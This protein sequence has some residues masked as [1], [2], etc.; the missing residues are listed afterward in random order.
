MKLRLF[1]A[2]FV[3]ALVITTSVFLPQDA[4]AAPTDSGTITVTGTV[5]PKGTSISTA[6]DADV[7]NNPIH[8]EQEIVVTVSY[9]STNV[10]S[11]PLTFRVEWDKA[12]VEGATEPN[13]ELIEYVI[14][15]AT[16]AY[17]DTAPVV[18]LQNRRITWS[19]AS[20]P[21]QSQGEEVSFRLRTTQGYTGPLKATIPL[22]V[23]VLSPVG[24]ADHETSIEYQ[25]LPVS[26]S[27]TPSPSSS[28]T[29]VTT[30]SS[31][32]GSA[33]VTSVQREFFFLKSLRVKSL[34]AV[35]ARI[36]VQAS[37]PTGMVLHFGTD[38]S[39]MDRSVSLPFVEGVHDQ[40]FVLTELLPGSVYFF[41]VAPTQFPDQKSDI[42]MLTT[43]TRAPNK[44]DTAQSTLTVTQQRSVIYA[45]QMELDANETQKPIVIAKNSVMDVSLK[46]PDID[47]VFLVEVFIRSKG[48]LGMTTD[49]FDVDA[50]QGLTTKM[51]LVSDDF[52]VGKLRAPV[53][54]GKYE[55]VSR[56]EDSY[57][58]IEEKTIGEVDVISPL[59]ILDGTTG[60]PVEHAQVFLFLLN[61]KNRLYEKVSNV[62][63]SIPN[64][65]LSDYEGVVPLNLFP[66]KYKAEI[67]LPGYKKKEV[68]FEV[69]SY[70]LAS[71]PQVTLEREASI[72]GARIQY[73][74]GLLVHAYRNQADLVVLLASSRRMYEL[75]LYLSGTTLLTT[76]LFGTSVRCCPKL[77][78]GYWLFTKYDNTFSHLF[79]WIT[80]S[81][82]QFLRFVVESWLFLCLVFGIAFISS[83]GLRSGF[84]VFLL[85]LI[86][87]SVWIFTLIHLRKNA[88][89]C[90][91]QANCPE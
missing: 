72:F 22:K 52:Y 48:V 36:G 2:F 89:D 13:A 35:S 84:L 41:Q 53:S 28:T 33:T 66:G 32:T 73:L 47:D 75:F 6:I 57:G 25:Y 62:T 90:Q 43:S 19:I 39:F 82:L 83:F 27:S 3:V 63:T 10:A 29:A 7:P 71:F 15:S 1:S 74:L 24:A 18:D 26:A 17:G 38:P 45:G 37:I 67:S 44:I 30:P 80:Y 5:P 78:S 59:T 70:S 58:N 14:G 79:A 31:A 69:G 11:I 50:L 20:L 8:Q 88:L 91:K 51:T 56:I 60:E 61:E 54:N 16:K 40:E 46:I 81:F 4:K 65:S 77:N 9:G 76:I 85:A 55:M 86:A 34:G 68:L 21:A 64:P 12:T 42:F 49:S 87:T 23:T